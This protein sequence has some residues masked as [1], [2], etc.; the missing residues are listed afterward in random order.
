MPYSCFCCSS[1]YLSSAC[2]WYKFDFQNPAKAFLLVLFF[3]ICPPMCAVGSVWH[4]K[5][6]AW[7]RF[8][9]THIY[10]CWKYLY[11]H[12]KFTHKMLNLQT[13]HI[14]HKVWI[15][16]PRETVVKDIWDR[17][18]WCSYS[19]DCDSSFLLRYIVIDRYHSAQCHIQENA[20][21]E[22]V[23]CFSLDLLSLAK[24]MVCCY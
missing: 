15:F 5:D 14:W 18:H 2:A 3:F 24:K 16:L 4:W 9:I 6:H 7:S 1:W 22:Y 13:L 23:K 21:F 8:N 11:L 10:Q 20:V 12:V 19:T 17:V